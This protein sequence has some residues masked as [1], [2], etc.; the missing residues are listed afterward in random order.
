MFSKV[1]DYAK[2]M[3]RIKKVEAMLKE[4]S[5]EITHLRD[6]N[7]KLQAALDAVEPDLLKAKALCKAQESELVTLR[8]K[9]SELEALFEPTK[10]ENEKLKVF[11][12]SCPCLLIH[13]H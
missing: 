1:D 3:A 6:E 12:P 9:Y 13:S 11:F 2:K 10:A 5:E 8:A 4:Y 7:D